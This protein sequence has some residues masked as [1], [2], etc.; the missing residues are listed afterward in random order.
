MLGFVISAVVSTVVSTGL[1]VA[2]TATSIVVNVAFAV[3]QIGYRWATSLPLPLPQP[4][5]V[6][7]IEAPPSPEIKEE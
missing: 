3:V 5:P 6:L 4:P 2:T 1:V 7:L